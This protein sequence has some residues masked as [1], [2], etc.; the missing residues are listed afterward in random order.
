MKKL[1][2]QC[3]TLENL[4]LAIEGQEL[5]QRA[6][7][8]VVLLTT[9]FAISAISWNLSLEHGSSDKRRPVAVREEAAASKLWE[10]LPGLSEDICC[11]LTL[12]HIVVRGAFNHKQLTLSAEER[13]SAI[14][15]VG[16][17]HC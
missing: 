9:W 11:G 2:C 17:M 12:P 5:W 13:C 14:P 4:R 8:G 1:S 16:C 3:Q 7:S 15:A 10:G 6:R